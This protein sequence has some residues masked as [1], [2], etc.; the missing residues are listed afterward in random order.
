MDSISSSALPLPDP[1]PNMQHGRGSAL[2]ETTANTWSC[3]SA[4]P[5]CT[6]SREHMSQVWVGSVGAFFWGSAEVTGAVDG[7][8]TAIEVFAEELKIPV[9][10]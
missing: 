6:L 7:F 3:P 8:G 9:S 5:S 2:V 1:D 10:K 4:A